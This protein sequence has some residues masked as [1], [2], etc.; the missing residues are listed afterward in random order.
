MQYLSWHGDQSLR[1]WGGRPGRMGR[2]SRMRCSCL[3]QVQVGFCVNTEAVPGIWHH[4][5]TLCHTAISLYAANVCH[6]RLPVRCKGP[7]SSQ[8][9]LGDI[10]ELAAFVPCIS[11]TGQPMS[12]ASL[13]RVLPIVLWGGRSWW[14]LCQ[15]HVSVWGQQVW[16]Q[17]ARGNI[18]DWVG[19]LAGIHRC[20][21][22]HERQNSS[23]LQMERLPLRKE[24][25]CL[26]ANLW[27]PQHLPKPL[28]TC[29]FHL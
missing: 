20:C 23:P 15:L 1:N 9:P 3:L 7:K 17:E 16:L 19:T 5:V 29:H 26:H 18:L 25:T 2:F 4:L 22:T 8:N 10:C 21:K 24:F 28:T 6:V 13:L 12:M 11:G 14:C 27:H